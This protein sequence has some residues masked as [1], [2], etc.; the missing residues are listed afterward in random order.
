MGFTAKRRTA[1]PNLFRVPTRL[2]RLDQR[3]MAPTDWDRSAAPEDLADYVSLQR[4]INSTPTLAIKDGAIVVISGAPSVEAAL[5]VDPPI[6]SIICRSDDR[7]DGFDGSVIPT[8]AREALDELEDEHARYWQVLYFA[9]ALSSAD[10]ETVIRLINQTNCVLDPPIA[11]V[12]G[13]RSAVG[14]RTG[15][16]TLDDGAGRRTAAAAR[17]IASNY[18]ISSF[19]G[20]RGLF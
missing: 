4:Q 5:S 17:E 19:N 2:I 9:E 16:I 14:W 8:T 6:E 13:G 18:K 11:R 1:G 3:Y 15:Y 20:I 7:L 12:I 10:L